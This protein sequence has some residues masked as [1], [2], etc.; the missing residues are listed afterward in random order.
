MRLKTERRNDERQKDYD[1]SELALA[2]IVAAVMTDQ[3]GG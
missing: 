3:A 1:K 2:L